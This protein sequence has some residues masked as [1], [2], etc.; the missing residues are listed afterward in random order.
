MFDAHKIRILTVTVL[1]AGGVLIALSPQAPRQLR[2]DGAKRVAL[3]IGNDAYVPPARPLGNAVNDA[4][5]MASVLRE[6]GFEVDPV[7][8][9]STPAIARAVLNTAS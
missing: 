9:A 5:A 7:Y 6:L 1:L 8:N 3:V 4:R 2:H